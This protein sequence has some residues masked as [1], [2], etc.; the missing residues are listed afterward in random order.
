M[1]TLGIATVLMAA[2]ITGVLSTN[3][4]AYA[5]EESATNTEQEINKRML[6]AVNQLTTTAL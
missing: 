1:K 3:P 4:I 5:Q 2:A 6:E